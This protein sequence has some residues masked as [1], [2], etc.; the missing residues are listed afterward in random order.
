M[1]LQL[2]AQQTDA[3]RNQFQEIKAGAEKGNAEDQ[4]NLGL[5]YAFGTGVVKDYVEGS[6]ILILT[7]NGFSTGRGEEWAQRRR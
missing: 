1:A 2:P 7:D 4:L 6:A 3:D 5:H